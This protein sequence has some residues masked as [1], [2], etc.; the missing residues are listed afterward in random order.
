MSVVLVLAVGRW[1][2]H[3]N[4]TMI[5][6]SP[7][8]QVNVGEVSQSRKSV[9]LGSVGVPSWSTWGSLPPA[10][11]FWLCCRMLLVFLPGDCGFA[12]KEWFQSA[13]R[14]RSVGF[15]QVYLTG[16]RLL[17][18]F[19]LTEREKVLL[20]LSDMGC[21][22]SSNSIRS[23]NGFTEAS[24]IRWQNIYASF[25]AQQA[26]CFRSIGV[27]VKNPW[28]CVHTFGCFYSKISPIIMIIIIIIKRVS[29][30]SR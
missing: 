27:C 5:F 15:L 24:Y 11:I 1:W 23:R 18:C 6:I 8:S 30:V 14:L 21:W 29:C 19:Q 2:E 26:S 4:E 28:C 25:Q 20:L 22:P 9:T 13:E 7:K 10:I 3:N 17:F 12:P 16:A